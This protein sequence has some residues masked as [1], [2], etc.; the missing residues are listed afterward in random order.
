MSRK[1]VKFDLNEAAFI[2][3]LILTRLKI[4]KVLFAKVNH[5]QKLTKA[6]QNI[7]GIENTWKSRRHNSHRSFGQKVRGEVIKLWSVPKMTALVLETLTLKTKAKIILEIGTSAGY[8]TLHLANG[9]KRN[10]GKVITL[11]NFSP[12][13]NLAKKFIEQS[14]LDNIFIIKGDA[15]HTLKNWGGETFDLVFLDADK[16]NYSQ[17]LR[18]LT[19]I[20]NKG[21]IIV[22]D[23]INDY[24]YMMEDYIKQLSGSHY[25]KSKVNPNIISTYIAQLDNGLLVSR[26]IQ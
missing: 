21:A 23:N 18:L 12:K 14:G 7:E 3:D 22:A 16:E 6:L 11:E 20:L 8:S 10:K 4:K 5:N 9:A 2:S 24:G 1:K 15:V 13:I 17:Y 25:P 26:K 19:P